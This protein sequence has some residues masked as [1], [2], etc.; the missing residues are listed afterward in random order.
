[1]NINNFKISKQ[2]KPFIIAEMSNNHLCDLSIAKKIIEKAAEC[3]ADAIKIQTYTAD[4][5]TIECDKPEFI[6]QD[7]LWKGQSYYQLYKDIAMPMEWTSILFEHA[8]KHNIIIFS[9]PFDE[10]SVRLLETVNCPL[11]KIASF[12]IQDFALLKAVAQT[13]KPVIMSTGIATLDEIRK[14][15]SFLKEHGC[16]DVAILHCISS[17]PCSFEQMNLLAIKELASLDL[18]YGLS[19]HSLTNIPAIA[20]VAMGATIIEKHFTLDRALGG[21]DAAFSINPEEL[22]SLVNETESTWLALGNKNIFNDTKRPG[23][24]HGRSIYVTNPMK[25]GDT[26]SEKNTRIIRPGFGLSPIYYDE[27]LGKKVRT[28]ISF[29]S[30]L[31]WEHIHE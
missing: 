6:I 2:N 15:V 29:G 8:K 25:A 23:K 14:S 24:H 4:S 30:A 5:L 12:E 27:I 21:P 16:S 26:L 17:Y 22:T 31:T 3:G 13:G 11:Y 28:D 10:E 7:P 18:L 9:S 20:A 19:D 1:M